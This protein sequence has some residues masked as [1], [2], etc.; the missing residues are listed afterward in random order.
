M[1]NRCYMFLCA[2]V[3]DNEQQLFVFIICEQTRVGMLLFYKFSDI[4]R[5]I[6]SART[7]REKA[8]IEGCSDSNAVARERVVRKRFFFYFVVFSLCHVH[9]IKNP[10]KT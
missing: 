1:G 6:S 3:E 9:A 2:N 4:P 8:K 10:G 7:A 5:K